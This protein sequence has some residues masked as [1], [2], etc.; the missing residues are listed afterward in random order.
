MISK[1][2]A[3]LI[4]ATIDDYPIIHNMWLFY[5]YE[6][7][8]YCG[9][10]NG[11]EYPV[12]PDFIPDDLTSYFTNPNQAFLIKIKNELAGFMLLNK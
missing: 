3:Q 2:K 8:R 6:L 11:W 7:G 9:L 12:N 10:N 4:E 1:L 5:I